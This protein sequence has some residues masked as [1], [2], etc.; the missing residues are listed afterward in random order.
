MP[1][2]IATAN[3]EAK[4]LKA[5]EATQPLCHKKTNQIVSHSFRTHMTHAKTYCWLIYVSKW[6]WLTAVKNG[7]VYRVKECKPIRLIDRN[8]H[9]QNGCS[10]RLGARKRHYPPPTPTYTQMLDFY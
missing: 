5:L 6:W 7:I 9:P 4:K 8:Q 2:A 3:F 1:T 10:L